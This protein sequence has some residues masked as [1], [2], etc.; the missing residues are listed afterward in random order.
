MAPTYNETKVLERIDNQHFYNI[1]LGPFLAAL[2][3]QMFMMGVLTLQCWTYF[4]TMA[5]TDTKWHRWL[6]V[7]MFVTGA[8]QTATDFEIMYATF[9]TG[10]GRIL[11]W[12][13]FHWT[14]TYELA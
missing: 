2:A 6:V 12:D 14:L 3:F 5:S 10:F 13:K 8:I 7:T 4:E 1:N 11:Y 9:V